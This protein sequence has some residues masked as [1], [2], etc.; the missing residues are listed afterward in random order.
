[1]YIYY[2]YILHLNCV[3]VLGVHVL[4]ILSKFFIL[5]KYSIIIYLSKSCTQVKYH[6][7]VVIDTGKLKTIYG[8]YKESLLEQKKKT[9]EGK[10]VRT[11]NNI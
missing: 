4:D 9:K 1:M 7:I 6:Y 3:R 2:T 10:K 5:S 8:I 11:R